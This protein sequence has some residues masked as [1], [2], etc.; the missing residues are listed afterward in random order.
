MEQQANPSQS[1]QTNAG[2]STNSGNDNGD[3]LSRGNPNKQQTVKS[4]QG[5]IRAKSQK[6]KSEEQSNNKR[7]KGRKWEG[8]RGRERNVD[9]RPQL[10]EGGER[11]ERRPKKKVACFIGYSGHGYHGMQ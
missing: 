4:R 6:R 3:E 2:E 1:R 9:T 8:P 7:N 5:S 11:E 10:G